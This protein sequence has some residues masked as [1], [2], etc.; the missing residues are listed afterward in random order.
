MLQTQ[1]FFLSGIEDVELAR[2]NAF[3]AMGMFL[4]CFVLSAVGIWY[5][6]QYKVEPSS[7]EPEAEYQLS[8]DNVATYGTST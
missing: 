4:V 7:V 5:D 2:N 6:S 8:N 1:P 3:G